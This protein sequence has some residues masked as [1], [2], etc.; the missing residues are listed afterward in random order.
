MLALAGPIAVDKPAL[1]DKEPLSGPPNDRFRNRLVRLPFPCS[2]I[3]EAQ[4][5]AQ[6]SLRT[7]VDVWRLFPCAS[8]VEP[9]DGIKY[10][11]DDPGI[12]NVGAAD[13]QAREIG[14]ANLVGSGKGP[15]WPPPHPEEIEWAGLPKTRKQP[16]DSVVLLRYRKRPHFTNGLQRIYEPPPAVRSL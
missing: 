8:G 7:A 5:P 12:T 14:D 13:P 16:S 11:N 2:R 4:R 3:I 15:Q 9:D 1:I 10:R 6:R